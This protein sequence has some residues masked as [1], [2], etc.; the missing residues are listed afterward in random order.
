MKYAVI[1]ARYSSDKE[2]FERVSHGEI[3][4]SVMDDFNMR[5]NNLRILTLCP[6]VYRSFNLF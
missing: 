4:Q 2:L 1:Y 5:G 6:V 3:I